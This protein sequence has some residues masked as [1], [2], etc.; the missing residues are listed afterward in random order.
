ML[1]IDCAHF[2]S[3]KKFSKFY[4]VQKLFDTSGI[5][6]MTYVDPG[7]AIE[8]YLTLLDAEAVQLL[9]E[10]Q[11]LTQPAPSYVSWLEAEVLRLR[12]ERQ[13]G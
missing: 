9:A 13:A 12:T 2:R 4:F 10:H 3:L 8:S 7:Q 1:E 5:E 11:A 6:T